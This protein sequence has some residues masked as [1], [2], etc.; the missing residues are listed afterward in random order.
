MRG[1]VASGQTKIG[2]NCLWQLRICSR[3]PHYGDN[4]EGIKWRT[5]L[6]GHVTID[7]LW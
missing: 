4:A 6:G 3:L 1:T 5:F 2:N 7:L